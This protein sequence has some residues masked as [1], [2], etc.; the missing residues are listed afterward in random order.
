MNKQQKYLILRFIHRLLP[1]ITEA[2]N[3]DSYRLSLARFVTL[4]KKSSILPEIKD[5][6]EYIENNNY[7][8]IKYDGIELNRVI[9]TDEFKAHGLKVGEFVRIGKM[10][11]MNAKQIKMELKKIKNEKAEKIK[12]WGDTVPPTNPLHKRRIKTYKEYRQRQKAKIWEGR[13]NLEF[14]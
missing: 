5:V 9:L 8:V 2:K 7:G 6:F 11:N 14:D 12:N 10:I 13:L 3:I 1:T 4:V